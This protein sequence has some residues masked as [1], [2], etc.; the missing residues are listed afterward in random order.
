MR[1][2]V[3]STLTKGYE[4]EGPLRNYCEPV[5]QLQKW[6]Q[7]PHVLRYA[8]VFS[9]IFSSPDG[10]SLRCAEVF[11]SEKNAVHLMKSLKGIASFVAVATTGSFSAAAKLQGVSAV[12]TS[13]NVA[14]L[15]RQLGVRLFQRTTRKLSLT[16]EGVSFFRQCEGPLRELQ[17]AQVAA[18]QS[19][20][21]LSGMV[22]VTSVSPIA[23]GYL[24]PLI[25]AFH[26]INPKVRIELHLD[27]G[28]SDMIEQGFDVGIRVGQLRDSTLVARPIANMPFVVCG[29]TAYLKLRGVPQTLAELSN[30]NCVRLRRPGRQEPFPWFLLGM[31]SALDKSLQGNF[32]VTDFHAVMSAAAQGQGLACVPLPMAMP[33]FRTGQLKPVLTEHIDPQFIVYVHYPNRKNLP[34][35]TRTFV[36]F[37]LKRL[38]D[39]LDLQTNH[40]E[41][42]A[43]F[44]STP[45]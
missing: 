30:H 22:R 28:V 16:D 32:S 2:S 13:K 9:A 14:T 27:D 11:Q 23:T 3:T 41:L 6:L 12:A 15:E 29:S 45:I 5:R 4:S 38:S 26:A 42:V 10:L 1:P 39:E 34:E 8:P 33:L 40:Q 20:K 35:R 21:S 43:P 37:V 36:D 24:L 44:V 18:E 31:D 19:S 7:N 25:P 17:A